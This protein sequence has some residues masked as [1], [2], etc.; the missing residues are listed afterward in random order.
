MATLL[1]FQSSKI[2]DSRATA[3]GCIFGAESLTS[4]LVSIVVFL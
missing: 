4:L 2:L 1:Y 3:H